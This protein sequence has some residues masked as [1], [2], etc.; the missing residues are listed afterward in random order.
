M[1]T[2]NVELNTEVS[3]SPVSGQAG[4]GQDVVIFGA[5]GD[6][7]NR[8]ILP[9]LGRLSSN[10]DLRVIG[11]GRRSMSRQQFGDQVARSSGGP[12]LSAGAC[13][14]RLDYSAM[15]DYRQLRNALAAD[16]RPMVFYLATPPAIFGSI[17]SGL[18]SSGLVRRGDRNRVVVEKPLGRDAA[19]AATLNQQLA[20]LF[21]ESQVYRIDHYLGK[22]TVQNVLAFRF[23]NAL[24]ESIWNRN[25]IDSIQITAAEQLDIV[26]RA[27]Y[28]DEVGAVRDM[29][30]NH[31]LQILALVTMEAPG[32]LD[33]VDIRAAK[34]AL[35]R[36]VHP[37]EPSAAVAGQYDGYLS[38][39]GVPADSRRE[40]YAAARVSIENWRWQAVPIFLRTGKA[41]PR[42][43]TEVVV[44]LKEAPRLRIADRLLDSIPTFVVLRIQPDEGILLRIGAKRPGP[45]FE[46]VPAGMQL[47]YR[48]VARQRLPD[49]YD[50]VLGEILAGGQVEFPGPNEIVRAWEI[51]DPLIRTWESQGRPEIYA[52]GSWGPKSADDL[53]ATHGG[54]R[55]LDSTALTPGELHP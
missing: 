37:L 49:A 29:V 30:Q 31:I 44:R 47:D 26:E 42:Q 5:S 54:G 40:T 23:S 36:A 17:L 11:V 12:A 19:T 55:W 34:E 45:Q 41:L 21:D 14:I 10:R 1:M 3:A 15:D 4:P 18:S 33:P 39:D 2:V 22:D 27:G 6:L 43:M 50:N 20:D 16:G 46:L 51:V 53:I 7:S 35:L 28:Y 24:F 32:S 9:A 13:W 48:A 38:T 8:K 25:F 52:R